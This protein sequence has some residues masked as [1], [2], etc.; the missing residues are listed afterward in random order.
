MNVS[1]LPAASDELKSAIRYHEAARPGYGTVFAD[2]YEYAIE[3]IKAD[4]DSFAKAEGEYR[5]ISLR[6]FPYSLVFRRVGDAEV[7]I[8]AVAHA[9]RRQGYWRKRLSP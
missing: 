6:I 1:L 4:P 5:S 8:V 3:R 9:K 7:M 2:E